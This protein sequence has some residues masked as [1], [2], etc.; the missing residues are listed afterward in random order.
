[1][2]SYGSLKTDQCPPGKDYICLKEHEGEISYNKCRHL[3]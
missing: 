2:H 1:M 3:V